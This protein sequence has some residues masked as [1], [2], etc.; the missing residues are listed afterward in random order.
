MT[1]FLPFN[2]KGS[3]KCT[4]AWKSY[5]MNSSWESIGDDQYCKIDSMVSL[6]VALSIEM[7]NRHPSILYSS[8]GFLCAK[9]LT[10]TCCI[11]VLH[12]YPTARER[13]TNRWGSRCLP[14]SLVYSCSQDDLSRSNLMSLKELLSVSKK[15][16][17]IRCC[18]VTHMWIHAETKTN[19]YLYFFYVSIIKARFLN[20]IQVWSNQIITEE[21]P[22]KINGCSVPPIPTEDN[23]I[24]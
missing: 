1:D 20:N 16:K 22:E 2:T 24:L 14:L 6:L 10:F 17:P 11:D 13:N 12:E 4:L 8:R 5:H 19:M 7:K 9:L 23:L 15:A 18:S 3:R 21:L